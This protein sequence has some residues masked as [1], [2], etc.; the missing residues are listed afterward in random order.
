MQILSSNNTSN[1][2]STDMD[3]A[4]SRKQIVKDLQQDVDDAPY[5][6]VKRL[7]LANKFAELKYPDLTAGEAYLAL[8]L[9]DETGDESG[10]YHEQALETALHDIESSGATNSDALEWLNNGI[11]QHV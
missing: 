6:I 10:E 5:S 7:K 1:L 3:A 8:L 9:C 4:K 2:L 11:E